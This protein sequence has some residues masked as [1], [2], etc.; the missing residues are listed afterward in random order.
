MRLVLV[1]VLAIFPFGC[2]SPAPS[3]GDDAGG[4]DDA[5]ASLCG[6]GVVDPMEQCDD[7]NRTNGDGCQVDCTFTCVSTAQCDD[8]DPCNGAE[9][10]AL[11]THTCQ[12]G[13]PLA[14]GASCGT[15]KLCIAG[16]CGNAQCG[17]GIVTPPEE[18]D[19]GN[20]TNGDGCDACRFSCLSTDAM[21]NCAPADPC[22]GQGTCADTTHTCSAGTPLADGTPCPNDA[23][24]FCKAGVC[25]AAI[26]GNGIKETGEACDDGNS[27]DGDGCNHDCKLSCV[28]PATD[29]AAPPACQKQRCT[30]AHVCQAVADPSL[31]GTSCGSGLQCSGGSCAAP[32]AVCGNGIKETGEQCD[33]GSGNGPNT[34]CETNCKLSCTISPNSCPDANPCNGTETCGAATVSGMA[35]QKCSPGTP[36]ADGAACGTTPRSICLSKVCKPS[37]CGDGFVDSAG[38]EECEPPNTASCAANCKS[39]VCGNGRRDPGE[40]CDDGATSN[41]DGCDATCRFEQDHRINYLKMKFATDSFCPANQLGAAITGSTAQGQLQ[42]SLDSNIAD[43]MTSITMKFL[44]LDDLTG[45]SD[46]AIELGIL[47]ATPVMGAGYSGTSDLD[48]W[49]TV[50]PMSIDATRGPKTKM[51]GA[52]A[53]KVLTAGPSNIG[54]TLALGGAPATLRMTATRVSV[55][56]SST[57]SAPAASTG[58]TPGHIADEHLDPAVMSF[59]SLGQQMSATGEGKLCGNIS[60][61]SLSKVPIAMGLVGCGF[62]K[63]S[64]CYTASNSLLDAIVNGCTVFTDQIA[65]TQPDSGK[66]DPDAPPAGAGPPYK[67]TSTG[68][69]VTGCQDKS[70]N[71]VDL[72]ACLQD[73][74]YSSYFH[75]TT[76]RIILK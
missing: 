42:M 3:T 52:I 55:T 32:G 49:Y 58:A 31:D 37:Q 13:T 73:A 19:D 24:R 2:D 56:N 50:D 30:D 51:S 46:P 34:G 33:L 11:A 35:V 5:A 44:G 53:A 8:G 38:G 9:D 48:W 14:D 18:C 10:C 4:G 69:A 72:T 70:G 45:T 66:D 6:N 74:V 26:C 1:T 68:N 22:A 27:I 40:Q 65:A 20:V 41:L 28:T 29:C 60:A 39:I 16:A 21:R 59:P 63:C 23:T 17:D 47:N 36:L 12:K 61:L 7:G 67:L 62:L 57:V 76:D 75:F 15:G 43:G 54:L 71:A 64:Q 25:T